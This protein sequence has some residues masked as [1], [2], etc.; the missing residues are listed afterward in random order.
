M[1]NIAINKLLL[2]PFLVLCIVLFYI[3]LIKGFI[4][5]LPFLLGFLVSKAVSPFADW[6]VKHTRLHKGFVV[7]FTIVTFLALGGYLI[8]L[9]GLG[10][11]D[12]AGEVAKQLPAWSQAIL[13]YA[14]KIFERFKLW[15]AFIPQQGEL[16]LK[17][18]IGSIVNAL[19]SRLTSFASK[20]ISVASSLPGVLIGIVVTILSAFFFSKDSGAIRDTLGPTLYKYIGS[21]SIYINFKRD[22]LA[23][24]WGYLRAQLTLMSVTMTVVTTGLA[25]IGVK[26]ALAL[27]ILAG[28]V[29]SLPI[30]GPA[31]FFMPWVAVMALTGQGVLAV[32]LFILYVVTTVTR[33]LLEPKVLSAHI[34]VHPLLTLMG[35]Y[36]G[37]QFFGFPGIILGPF[38]MVTLVASYKRYIQH[39][40]LEEPAIMHRKRRAD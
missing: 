21:K 32:K 3:G 2:P 1:N 23:V 7:G 15:V 12:A 17:D 24:I 40:Q 8:Y 34:G 25:I 16:S 10:L 18:A 27:G 26:N 6:I 39:K 4:L 5:F 22:I 29:D 35:L 36:L 37:I 14:E 9:I 33:Q 11:I 28:I 38:T 30:L 31:A 13:N 20:G 19:S